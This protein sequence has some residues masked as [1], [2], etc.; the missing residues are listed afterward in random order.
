[1]YPTAYPR[2]DLYGGYSGDYMMTSHSHNFQPP[3]PP[4]ASA[5]QTID[6]PNNPDDVKSKRKREASSSRIRKPPEAPKR[7]KSSYILFF[8]AKQKEIKDEIGEGASVGEISKRSSEMWKS[9]SAEERAI[10]DAKAEEDKERYKLEKEKY[11]GPWQVPWK[12]AKK[13]P[14]APKRPMSA[15]LFYSQDKRRSIKQANPGMRNTE[16]SR[17][18]G[19]MWKKAT[20][21]LLVHLFQ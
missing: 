7:F 8:M 3:S 16:I 9:L 2:N 20:V 19:D 6:H 4:P 14:D 18:L 5:V 12:R 21:S 10:W 11:T 17:V 1:M 15:F 13:N